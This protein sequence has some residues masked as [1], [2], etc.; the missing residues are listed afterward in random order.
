MAYSGMT[1]TNPLALPRTIDPSKSLTELNPLPPPGRPLDGTA[2]LHPLRNGHYKALK[3]KITALLGGTISTG[4]VWTAVITPV[5]SGN[6]TGAADGQSAV[7]LTATV[8]VTETATA[9]GDLFVAAYLAS[10]Q[11]ATLAGIDSVTRIRELVTITNNAGTLTIESKLGGQTFTIDFTPQSGGSAT[12]TTVVDGDRANLRVGVFV[13]RD[14][15]AEDGFTPVVRLPETGDTVADI[16]GV[17][18]DGSRAAAIDPDEG[19]TYLGYKPGRDVPIIPLEG[20]WTCYAEAAVDVGDDIWVRVVAGAGE[21]AGA[22]NDTPDRT[23]AVYT[24]TP[25]AAN[26]TNFA[27]FVQ[28]FDED[29]V[30]VA[31]SPFNYTSDADGTAAEIVTGVSADLTGSAVDDY[32][33]ITGTSTL[34]LTLTAGYTLAFVSTGVGVLAVVNGTP[35]ANDHVK[36]TKG[37]F[38]RTTTA[39]GTAALDFGL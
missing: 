25:T 39:A 13:V 9:L 1:Q 18:A 38:A 15:V 2:D 31:T 16:Y 3:H 6:G 37:K 22:A 14:G 35:A 23:A 36:L 34:I 33:A 24:I 12:K 5:K 21:V 4:G 32:L 7:T 30:V 27:G 20:A 11:I 19:Y 8:G 28:V 26:A 10:G 29:G 17:V